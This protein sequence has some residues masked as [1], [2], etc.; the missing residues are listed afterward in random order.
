MLTK[1]TLPKQ[2]DGDPVTKRL[3]L[4]SRRD[5]SG[6]AIPAGRARTFTLANVRIALDALWLLAPR[7]FN[8]LRAPEYADRVRQLLEYL[9]VIVVSALLPSLS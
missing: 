4:Q 6:D 9:L 2:Y 3:W 1:F 8:L 7:A 5:G